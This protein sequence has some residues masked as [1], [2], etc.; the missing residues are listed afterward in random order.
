LIITIRYRLKALKE[1]TL[2]RKEEVKIDKN[3]IPKE[4]PTRQNLSS[5]IPF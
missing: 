5:H 2:G 3:R 1:L 4:S